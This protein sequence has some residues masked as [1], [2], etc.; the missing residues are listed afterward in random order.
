MTPRSTPL[1]VVGRGG[2]Y[3]RQRVAEAH[4]QDVRVEY[5]YKLGEVLEAALDAFGHGSKDLELAL[6]LMK[7]LAE[8]A[9]DRHAARVVRPA[10][11]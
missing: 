3:Y 7:A 9:K 2:T 10:D 11:D 1:T 5:E 8:D 4:A 6:E